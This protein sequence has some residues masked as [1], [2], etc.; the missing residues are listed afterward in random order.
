VF[1][2]ATLHD[3][4]GMTIGQPLECEH[5]NFDNGDVLQRTTTGLAYWRPSTNI[6]AFTTDGTNHWALVA[7]TLV[8]WLNS[9]VE[10]PQPNAAQAAYLAQSNPIVA[11]VDEAM[12]QLARVQ[13]GATADNLET[14]P[15]ADIGAYVDT[16]SAARDQ[17]QAIDPPPALSAYHENILQ[18]VD[19][20]NAAASTLLR[21]QVTQN[22]IARN[23][24]IAQAGA[25]L[26][27]AQSARSAAQDAYSAVLPIVVTA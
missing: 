20:T 23:A 6:S 18:V 3:H 22:R 8:Y 25:Q 7:G 17:L 12:A 2:F 27:E 13:D 19:A 10:P 11:Q 16:L 21:A 1:G 15:V 5:P 14:V 24:F 26:S 9:S 4:L